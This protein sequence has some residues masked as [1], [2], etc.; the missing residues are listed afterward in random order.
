[1]FKKIT[2]ILSNFSEGHPTTRIHLS[3]A[4]I[5]PYLELCFSDVGF[6]LS[7]LNSSE[8][9]MILFY[10]PYFPLYSS[11]SLL[12]DSLNKQ[13]HTWLVQTAFL[14]AWETVSL[15]LVCIYLIRQNSK[16]Q[17]RSLNSERL[18]L[19]FFFL[20]YLSLNLIS[21]AIFS[22]SVNGSML[23]TLNPGQSFQLYF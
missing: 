11:P 17:L 16:F 23:S 1:M 10:L 5:I 14:L 22:F 20:M 12:I 3:Y 15:L 13:I 8:C 6:S 2:A 19:L 7:V 18:S 21:V 9:S 4:G